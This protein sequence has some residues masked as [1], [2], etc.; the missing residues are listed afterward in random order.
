MAKYN[1]DDV[2]SLIAD[3]MNGND[4]A[5]WFSYFSRSIR[6]VMMLMKCSAENAENIIIKGLLKLENSGFVRSTVVF[7]EIT[8]EYA[9]ENYHDHNWYI[10]FS[11]ALDDGNPYLNQLSFHPLERPLKLQNSRILPVTYT[12][13]EDV[14]K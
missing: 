1:L 2:R 9:L 12:Q 7:D 4:D 13:E 3:F 8:D 10:K 6:P 11:V 5:I 14:W